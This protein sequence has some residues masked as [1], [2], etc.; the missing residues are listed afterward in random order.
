ME[1]AVSNAPPIACRSV[2]GHSSCR[3]LRAPPSSPTRAPLLCASCL[4]RQ[5]LWADHNRDLQQE[6][7]PLCELCNALVSLHLRRLDLGLRLDSSP[8]VPGYR[9]TALPCIQ[10][11][12]FLVCAAAVVILGQSSLDRS[13]QSL[14]LLLVMAGVFVIFAVH[15]HASEPRMRRPLRRS[16]SSPK[17][18]L[19]E[20]QR[21]DEEDAVS[22]LRDFSF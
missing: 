8:A 16:A 22:K 19:Q 4:C 21:L 15:R 11:A 17:P 10:V 5:Q 3:S 9:Q 7:P 13:L 12:L 20:L 1:V 18:S 14:C 6:S 2:D